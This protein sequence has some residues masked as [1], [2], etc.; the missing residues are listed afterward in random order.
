VDIDRDSRDSLVE[1]VREKEHVQKRLRPLG[2][3]Q[4]RLLSEEQG[5]E[6]WKLS[7]VSDPPLL[8]FEAQKHWT[9]HSELKRGMCQPRRSRAAYIY[10]IEDEKTYLASVLDSGERPSLV[11][12]ELSALAGRAGEGSALTRRGRND[13]SSQRPISFVC[14]KRQVME[15]TLTP[16]LPPVRILWLLTLSRTSEPEADC[17]PS[18]RL[19]K[20]E[21]E[22]GRLT[23]GAGTGARTGGNTGMA[24]IIG[25]G[26]GAAD[27]MRGRREMARARIIVEGL[28]LALGDGEVVSS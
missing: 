20:L 17:Q 5:M 7:W 6:P 12:A 13:S 23:S 11:L 8:S 9:A 27:A 18:G 28:F 21:D 3:P 26:A 25:A 16:C 2:P 22:V 1:G 15:G 19:P 10:M 24:W 14:L 4:L